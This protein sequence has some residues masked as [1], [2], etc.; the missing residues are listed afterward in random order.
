[1][2]KFLMYFLPVVFV[3][4][5]LILLVYFLKEKSPAFVSIPEKKENIAEEAVS[6]SLVPTIADPYK[7][8]GLELVEDLNKIQTDIEKS[9]KEDTRLV[10]PEMYFESGIAE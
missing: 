3:I 4:A 1:M 9:K 6:P 7:Q 10:P 2:K 5:I 8:K